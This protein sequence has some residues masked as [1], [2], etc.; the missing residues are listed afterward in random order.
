MKCE[1]IWPSESRSP[2]GS[3]CW[4]CESLTLHKGHVLP[5]CHSPQQAHFSPFLTTTHF[6]SFNITSRSKWH[7]ECANTH[8]HALLFRDP[9]MKDSETIHPTSFFKCCLPS[10]TSTTYKTHVVTLCLQSE[11]HWLEE[12]RATA[13]VS[14]RP[15]S[16]CPCGPWHVPSFRPQFPHSSFIP[17][18]KPQ[19]PIIETK[20]EFSYP[21]GFCPSP[22][23]NLMCSGLSDRD[24]LLRSWRM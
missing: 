16:K 3:S 5:V 18:S 14:L 10:T 9:G 21:S 7:C 11:I 24:Q 17:A 8:T 2:E 4:S 12:A 1:N 6:N 13:E 20:D 15:G 23:P 19:K 22:M